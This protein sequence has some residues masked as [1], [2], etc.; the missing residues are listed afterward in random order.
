M[1]IKIFI[2][3]LIFLAL[4]FYSLKDFFNA[5]YISNIQKTE[6]QKIKNLKKDNSLASKIFLAE[7]LLQ[8]KKDYSKVLDILE[9]LKTQKKDNYI[10]NSLFWELFYRKA[11]LINSDNKSNLKQKIFIQSEK[12]EFLKK[13]L[14]YYRK[15]LKQK[16]LLE[17]QKNI[18]FIEKKLNNEKQKLKKID[19]EKKK[20]NKKKQESNKNNNKNIKNKK[21]N[22]PNNKNNEKKQ[23]KIDNFLKNYEKTLKDSQ[24]KLKKYYNKNY[25][26]NIKSLKDIFD[27]NIDIKKNIKDW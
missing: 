24:Q 20:Q 1:K 14:I 21:E 8:E 11:E 6:E 22:N 25:D 10:I 17:T 15:S 9:N 19:E 12:I 26:D 23:E 2:L 16:Y 27:E 4:N 3:I 7:F 13:S 18:L 5:F